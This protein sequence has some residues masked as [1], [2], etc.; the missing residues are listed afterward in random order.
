MLFPQRMAMT[1]F[2]P[3]KVTANH[4]FMM[5]DNRDNSLD[6]R[7]IGLASRDSFVG[8]ANKNVASLDPDHWY[9][10]RSDRFWHELK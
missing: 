10:P 4:Y 6:S 8:R 2:G 1:S 5:G 3:V 7:Y 9:L